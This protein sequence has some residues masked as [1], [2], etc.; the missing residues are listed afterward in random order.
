MTVLPYKI[1][2]DL[3]DYQSQP[4]MSWKQ[5]IAAIKAETTKGA[6]E[7]RHSAPLRESQRVV[8][9]KKPLKIQSLAPAD[10]LDIEADQNKPQNKPQ[11]NRKKRDTTHHTPDDAFDEDGPSGRKSMAGKRLPPMH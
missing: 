10:P 11:S 3:S 4:S 2:I 8:S 9:E 6:N 7:E 1:N 5:S